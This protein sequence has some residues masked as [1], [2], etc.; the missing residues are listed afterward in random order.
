MQSAC[1]TQPTCALPE[2]LL[3]D[4]G[5]R[6]AR[7]ERGPQ[8]RQ[9]AER[10]LHDAGALHRQLWREDVTERL[11][12]EQATQK[13]NMCQGAIDTSG[14]LYIPDGIEGTRESLPGA[15]EAGS[16]VQ[17]GTTARS[18]SNPKR[19]AVVSARAP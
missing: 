4:K 5:H 1:A 13:A 3:V 11:G 8:V 7:L 16:R 10:V 15:T 6:Q 2:A 9:P 12:R 17:L 18:P 19:K 14:T